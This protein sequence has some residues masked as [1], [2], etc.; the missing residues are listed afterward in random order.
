MAK[1]REVFTV[2]NIR[3]TKETDKKG[4]TFVYVNGIATTHEH[5]CE[6]IQPKKPIFDFSKTPEEKAK[7]VFAKLAHKAK[8]ASV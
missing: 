1:G 3:F 5:A 6:Y 4:R 8:R 7:A 2:N